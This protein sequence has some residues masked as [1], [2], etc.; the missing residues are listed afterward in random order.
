MIEKEKIE[1]IKRSIDL[2]ALVES[3]GIKLKKNGQCYF[4]LCPFHDDHNPSLSIN[5]STNLWQCFGCG[6]GGDGIRF[7]ELIDRVDFKEAVRRLSDNG[8]KSSK[9]S[10]P[11]KQP[12]KQP[13]KQPRKQ[14]TNSA[15]DLKLLNRVIDL[16]HTAFTEDRRAK[17]YLAQRGIT[18]NAVYSEFKIGFANGTLLNL[19]PADGDINRK[20]KGIGILNSQGNEHFYGCVI[21]PLYDLSGNPSGLYGRRLEGMTKGTPDHLYLPGQ[22]CGL[23]NWQAAKSHKKIILTESIIDALTLINAGLRN[24]IPSYGTNGLT[25][26]HL[27]LFKQYEVHTIYICFDAD[28]SGRPAA[29]KVSARLK[30]EG[31]CTHTIDL[32][33]GQDINSFFLLTARA[34][35]AFRKLLDQANTN[36]PPGKFKAVK[37][38]KEAVKEEIKAVKEGKVRV[39]R[40]EYGFIM[41][42]GS[43]KY[44]LRGLVK[45]DT[46]LKATVK[47]IKMEKS[48]KRFHLDTVDLYSARSRA[49]F[50]RGLCDLFGED[51]KVI[52]QDME[53]LLDAAENYQRPEDV[54]EDKNKMTAEERQEALSFLKNPNMFDE[55]LSDFETLGFTGEEMNKLLCYIAAISR[56]MDEPLSVM[57]QSRSAAG[58]S[59]LQD[60]VLSLLPQEDYIKYTR[61]TDQALFYKESDSLAHKLLA[62]EELD[63]MSGAIYSIRSIQ[64]SKKITIAYTGKDP[65]TGKMRTEENTVEGP[66]MVF[67]TTTQVDIDSETASR[68]MFISIDESEEMTRKVLAKQRKSQTM[69]GMINK[70]K[71]ARI[72]K[73][74]QNVNRLLKT[75]LY[76][77]NPYAGLLTFTTKSLRVR[78][79]HTKYLNLILAIAYLLQY[80]R[81]VRAMEYN[82]QRIEYINTTLQDIEK[83]NKIANEVLGRSLHELTPPSRNLLK[84]IREMVIIRCKEKNSTPDEYHFTRR[85]VREYS[86]WSDF[87]IKTHIKQLEEL[88]YLYSAVGKKGKEYIY[89]LLVTEKISHDGPFLVG[90]VDIEHLEKKA[91]KAGISDE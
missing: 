74:H 6:K 84:V 21:F 5:P 22:R 86:G 18:N 23:F 25:F 37:E 11:K 12:P 36:A 33:E 32:P 3:K 26:D 82:G 4:G 77:F 80:Q 63:G 24:T 2:V 35:Q 58:K 15:K 59:F 49:F 51:E 57:I 19:L 45:R 62:I 79:D 10:Y 54:P 39:A 8:L 30:A 88:E 65:A 76:V 67:I 34:V 1:A 41:T 55:I 69:E 90:L 13:P 48:K 52:S 71:S 44:E 20:L 78:R 61:L 46:K 91:K 43:R 47:G 38:E 66:L 64:S 14:A 16:Y 29:K 72:I 89:E 85:D 40:T 56:K 27:K 31:I 83:A 75:P 70:L 42:V 50:V 7:V 60:T 28:K 87:Q 73:K 68:F 81:K 17:E 9:G 53:N